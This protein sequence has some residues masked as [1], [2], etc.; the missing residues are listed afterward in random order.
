MTS[1]YHG[2]GKESILLNRIMKLLPFLL[3]FAIIN[4]CIEL[5]IS[6]P[7]FPS[8][9]SH[10]RVSENIVGMTITMNLIGFCIASIVYG[11]LSDAFGR[12]RIMII[13]NGVLTIGAIGC[14]IAPS[15]ECLLFSR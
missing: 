8:I 2:T 1:Y 6:A 12:R 3:I 9:M 5:E 4:S 10:F 7:S 13:G 15:I 11:T 14:V